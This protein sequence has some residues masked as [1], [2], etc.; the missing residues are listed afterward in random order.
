MRP[1]SLSVYTTHL[2]FFRE[3]PWCDV[4]SVAARG[5]GVSTVVS[6]RPGGG[7]A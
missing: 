5:G 2:L 4:A 1:T 6:G 3:H 7:S